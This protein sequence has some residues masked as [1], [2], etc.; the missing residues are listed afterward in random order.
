MMTY[1]RLTV[2]AACA[3][4]SDYASH[5][6]LSLLE[7]QWGIAGRTN[8]NSKSQRSA[9]LA[10][11]AIDENPMV[12]T[13]NGQMPLSIAVI[14]EAIKAPPVKQT[15][16]YWLKLIAGLRFDGFDLD[17]V[18]T[19]IPSPNTWSVTSTRAE[20]VLRPIYPQHIP[21]LNFREAEDE[22]SALL[23]RFDFTTSH[24][25]L[26]QAISAF[27]RGDWA[28][29]N[30]QL[31]TFFES[32]LQEIAKACGSTGSENAI[33]TRKYLGELVPPFLFTEYNEWNVNEQ[34]PQFLGG[35]MA[36][37]HP[38]GSH[39]GLSEEDDCAFRL[40]ISLIC[41]RLLLRRFDQRISHRNE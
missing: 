28:A 15:S 23:K 22:V 9:D 30:A 41:A 10:R 34:K 18:E 25:H 6:D 1:N 8:S 11:I 21:A 40:H 36:R 7:N 38:A 37:M 14:E 3:V 27:S 32:Y 4:L 33:S 29:S 13:E 39:P 24:G 2:T 19:E 12:L 31:R 5:G 17:N 16:T 20:I 35:L 26:N